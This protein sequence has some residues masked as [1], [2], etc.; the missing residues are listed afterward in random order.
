MWGA[1]IA[2]LKGKLIAVRDILERN[3]FLISMI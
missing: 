1:A 3:K 2:T